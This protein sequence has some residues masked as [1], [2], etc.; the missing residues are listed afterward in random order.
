MCSH[1]LCPWLRCRKWNSKSARIKLSA[2]NKIY[3]RGIHC[4]DLKIILIN[5]KNNH[6]SCS[7]FSISLKN[8]LHSNVI[9]ETWEYQTDECVLFACE[10]EWMSDDHKNFTHNKIGFLLTK[11]HTKIRWNF[12]T[13]NPQRYQQE[14]RKMK[15]GGGVGNIYMHLWWMKLKLFIATI[16]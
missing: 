14:H 9:W 11:K 3:Y 13:R 8:H 15:K 10:G 12:T 1:S 2:V 16:Y 5:A 6:L 4:N 7:T